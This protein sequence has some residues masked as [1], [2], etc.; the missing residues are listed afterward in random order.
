MDYYKFFFSLEDKFFQISKFVEINNDNYKTYSSEISIAFMSACAEFEVVAK[1]LCVLCDSSFRKNANI[2]RIAACL[3][4][5]FPSIFTETVELSYFKIKM[6]PL[7]NLA[8]TNSPKWWKAYNSLKH[9]RSNSY[10]EANIENLLLALASLSIVNHYYVWKTNK[11]HKSINSALLYMSHLPEHFLLD[12]VNYN[13]PP[14][15]DDVFDI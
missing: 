11:P 2:L 15:S 6:V 5:H 8:P 12:S 1:A 7:S 14:N 9:D 4:I 10:S 3:T 13:S